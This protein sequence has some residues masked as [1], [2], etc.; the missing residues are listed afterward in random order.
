MAV[1]MTSARSVAVMAI[2]ADSHSGNET[3]R[4]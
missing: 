3:Q 1:P 2:S 4:G